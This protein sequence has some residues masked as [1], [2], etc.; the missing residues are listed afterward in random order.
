ML[1]AEIQGS[2]FLSAGEKAL[3]VTIFVVPLFV[4]FVVGLVIGSLSNVVIY[5]L[6]YYRSIW[7][8]PSHCPR[9]RNEIPW[10]DNI[11]IVSWLYLRG[12]CRFCKGPISVKY[13][14]VEL[15]SG[16]MY[17]GIM[18]RFLYAPYMPEPVGELN[19][20]FD[21]AAIPFLFKVYVFATFLLILA[22]IDIDHQLL[23]NRLTVSGAVIGLVLSP[24]M[25]P[26][27]SD[28]F[29]FAK[30]AL[31]SVP[32][33]VD[34]FLQSLLGMLVGGGVVFLIFLIGY[35][36]YRF[37]AMG[38]GD[39]KLAGMIGAFVGLGNIGQALCLGGFVALMWGPNL[40]KLWLG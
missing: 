1:A 29:P 20:H 15:V 5:R 2:D 18:Y 39:V 3:I 26:N 35:L 23:P 10:F 31:F 9:C 22:V 11:P 38:L 7:A 33:G 21:I 16:L 32:Q 30:G 24:F 4:A 28:V 25:L 13:P 36:I 27:R 40:M 6:V 12:R 34:G 37:A 8:P 17:A 14:I 19:L